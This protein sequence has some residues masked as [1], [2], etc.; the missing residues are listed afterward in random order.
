MSI[1]KILG[2]AAIFTGLLMVAA[3]VLLWGINQGVL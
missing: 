3:Q 1:V 2:L